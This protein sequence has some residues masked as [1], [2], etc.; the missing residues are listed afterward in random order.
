MSCPPPPPNTHTHTHTHTP[1]HTHTQTPLIVRFSTVIH[2]RG[3]PE[4]LRDPR[5]FAVKASK[6]W[7]GGEGE[8]GERDAAGGGVGHPRGF[9]VEARMRWGGGVGVGGDWAPGAGST[10]GRV[11]EARAQL[12]MPQQARRLLSGSVAPPRPLAAGLKPRLG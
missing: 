4:T 7:E 10:G 3:S 1:T 2:E 5:G 11:G 6:R 9:A 8:E 12:L